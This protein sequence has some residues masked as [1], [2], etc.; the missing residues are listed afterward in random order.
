MSLVSDEQFF[1]VKTRFSETASGVAVYGKPSFLHARH[2]HSVKL[3][4]AGAYTILLLITTYTIIAQGLRKSKGRRVLLAIVWLMYIN[5]TIIGMVYISFF[6]MGIDIIQTTKPN[7]PTSRD[8]DR[9]YKVLISFGSTNYILGDGVVVWRAWVL[10]PQNLKVRGFL[11]FCMIGSVAASI[12]DGVIAVRE[13]PRTHEERKGLG[14]LGLFLPL[15]GTN[16]V[17]TSLVAYRLW[18]YRA[19]WSQLGQDAKK[20]S[21]SIAEKALTIILELG[22]LFIF[23]LIIAMLSALEILGN[24]AHELL[25]CILPQLEG[26]Y[27]TLVILAVTYQQRVANASTSFDE[28]GV[29]DIIASSRHEIHETDMIFARGQSPHSDDQSSVEAVP[30]PEAKQQRTRTSY[31]RDG[32]SSV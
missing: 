12:I 18:E 20:H 25:E 13:V 9:L 14:T 31:R 2:W 8:F 32:L 7:P 5:A 28:F 3:S 16:L 27:L 4:P 1:Q 6:M 11:T 19:M 15:L 21:N 26:I 24:L 30:M 23:Y 29:I 22:I 17:A 10:Y